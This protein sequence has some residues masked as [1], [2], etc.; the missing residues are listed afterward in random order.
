MAM[1]V[2]STSGLAAGGEFVEGAE[3]RPTLNQLITR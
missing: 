1:A 3:P 2:V